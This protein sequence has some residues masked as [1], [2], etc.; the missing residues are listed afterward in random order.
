MDKKGLTLRIGVI[1]SGKIIEEFIVRDKKSVTIGSNIKNSIVVS[2][3]RLSDKYKLFTYVKDGEYHLNLTEFMTG[4]IGSQVFKEKKTITI[5]TKDRGKIEFSSKLKIL[6]QFIEAPEELVIPKRLPKEFRNKITDYIDWKFVAPL[7]ISLIIHLVWM[8]WMRT[9]DLNS[10]EVVSMDKIPD[11][12]REVITQDLEKKEPIKEDIIGDEDGDEKNKVK[13]TKKNIKVKDTSKMTKSERKA[14]TR[15]AVKGKSKVLS[16]LDKLRAGNAGGGSGF[17]Q[18]GLGSAGGG[19]DDSMS[20]SD[21]DS[22]G[23]SGS[24]GGYGDGDGGTGVRGGGAGA[25]S[26]TGY[27]RKSTGSGGPKGLGKDIGTN[28]KEVKT[29]K[30][31][32]V[33]IATTKM[34]ANIKEDKN[35]TKASAKRAIKKAQ[36]KV[37]GCYQK[38]TKKNNSFAGR[39]T[40]AILVGAGGKP[41]SVD[42]V[43][44]RMNDKSLQASLSKCIKKQLKRIKFPSPTNPPIQIKFTAAFSSGQ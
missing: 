9:L 14:A 35:L 24:G 44:A 16:A 18:V 40:I 12:F 37:N 31:K 3:K 11:R 13:D 26:G 10:V 2:D 30:R 15:K 27:G 41:L 38:E 34:N 43:S 32:R 17:G 20:L 7:T 42:I 8:L 28:R 21:L 33:A 22:T 19:G 1:E 39:V 23:Y 25:G 6:F 36:R 5:T 4:S 29:T